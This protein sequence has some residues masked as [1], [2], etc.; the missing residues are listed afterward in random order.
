MIWYKYPQLLFTYENIGIFFPSSEMS[1]DDQLNSI[2]R[3]TIYF[4]VS[5][6]LL[7]RKIGYIYI[8]IFVSILTIIVHKSS[9]FEN[10]SKAELFNKMNIDESKDQKHY[11][12]SSPNN[13]FMNISHTDYTKFPNRPAA[14]KWNDNN[15]RRNVLHNFDKGLIRSD[16]DIFH[17]GSSD[18]QYYTMP[19]TTIP[20]KQEDF[21]KWLYHNPNKT[22]KEH[23]M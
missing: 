9:D 19:S 1:F 8:L 16:N 18:R 6:V 12:K 2:M 15:V 14:G 10:K 20:N 22:K 21:A 11:Y 7:T 5:L 4:V 13:P 3:F 17:K 23:Y